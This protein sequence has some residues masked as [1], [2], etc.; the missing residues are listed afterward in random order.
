M[1]HDFKWPLSQ[2]RE[3]HLRRYN[4]RRS[5]L[6]IFL[7]DQTNYFLN[8]KKEVRVTNY[9]NTSL[10]V[11]LY[12]HFFIFSYEQVRNKVYS[13]MMLLRSV[14]VYG[15]RSPQELLKASGLTQVR[16]QWLG[17]HYRFELNWSNSFKMLIQLQND[18]V[19]FQ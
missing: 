16:K 13:R 3:V 10:F 2:I 9:T 4:L 19:S 18:C 15:T 7:I 11:A 8:F 17:F 6:E 1:G 14:S 5:A 12:N